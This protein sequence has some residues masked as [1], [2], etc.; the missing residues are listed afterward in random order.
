MLDE[1]PTHV[2]EAAE[3]VRAHLVALRGGAPFLSPEDSRLLL[4]WLDMGMGVPTILRALERAAESRRKRRSRIP[5][6][7]G[8]A[9]RHLGKVTRGSLQP[10]SPG[11]AHPLAPLAEVL[12]HDP[13]QAP[14]AAELEALP[15]HDH[16]ELLRDALG[17]VRRFLTGRWEG[18]SVHERSRRLDDAREDLLLPEHPGDASLEAMIEEHAR[19]RLRQDHPLL[20]AATLW[21]LVQPE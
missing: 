17:L 9:K 12:R 5:L 16:E 7:L 13:V 6:A 2:Q 1:V 11:L 15:A 8:H 20:T 21:D 18:M 4:E 3:D 10:L 14:L 19:D